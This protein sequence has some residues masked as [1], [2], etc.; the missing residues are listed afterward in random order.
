MMGPVPIRGGGLFQRGRPPSLVTCGEVGGGP[1]SLGNPST[2]PLVIGRLEVDEESIV[3]GLT[4]SIKNVVRISSNRRLR[5]AWSGGTRSSITSMRLLDFFVFS[6]LVV[7]RRGKE[8][9]PD[10]QPQRSERRT[11]SRCGEGARYRLPAVRFPVRGGAGA[12]LQ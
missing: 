3:E 2:S 4:R 7:K 6:S 8:S 11:C 12:G 9:Q 10:G 1:R 5:P